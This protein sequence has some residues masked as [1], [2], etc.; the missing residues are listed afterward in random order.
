MLTDG[1]EWNKLMQSKAFQIFLDK[2]ARWR[3]TVLQ[4]CIGTVRADLANLLARRRSSHFRPGHLSPIYNLWHMQQL[5][6]CA[7]VCVCVCVCGAHT[8][9]Q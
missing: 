8:L 9:T 3:S 5:R 4:I 7:C 6:G 1:R 2:L